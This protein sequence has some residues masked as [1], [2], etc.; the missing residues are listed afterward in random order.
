[1]S[2]LMTAFTTPTSRG[3]QMSWMRVSFYDEGWRVDEV[4]MLLFAL[5]AT[6]SLP[7]TLAFAVGYVSRSSVHLVRI[8]SESPTSPR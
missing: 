4:N 1:M 5:A 7:S 2:L 6:I 8:T 3:Y